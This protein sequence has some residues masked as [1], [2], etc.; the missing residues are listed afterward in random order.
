MGLSGGSL[1]RVLQFYST[2]CSNKGNQIQ[3][4]SLLEA[5][6]EKKIYKKRFYNFLHAKKI[7]FWYAIV[8]EIRKKDIKRLYG[9][10]FNGF[11]RYIL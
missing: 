3:F 7:N 11:M 6:A 10:V 4:V 2:D 5:G 1:E 8:V 9:C